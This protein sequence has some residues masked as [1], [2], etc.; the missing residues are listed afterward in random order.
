MHRLFENL[1]GRA[2]FGD[3]AAVHHRDPVADPPHQRQV[4]ADVEDRGVGPRLQFDEQI[5]D[6]RLDRDV[7]RG[8]GF[9]GDQQLRPGRERLRDHHALLHAARQLVRIPLHDLAG[10]GDARLRQ[11]SGDALVKDGL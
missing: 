10:I 9:V 2:D 7:E 6:A 1:V 11:R 5:E 8:G 3:P 4:V